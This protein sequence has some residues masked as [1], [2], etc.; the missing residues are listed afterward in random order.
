[1]VR[2][3]LHFWKNLPASVRHLLLVGAS[4][5]YH[6]SRIAAEAVRKLTEE[7]EPQRIRI[8][9]SLCSQILLAVWEEDPLDVTAAKQ[10]WRW[11][12]RFPFLTE[13]TAAL[14]DAV[15]K[16]SASAVRHRDNHISSTE[17]DAI[18]Q[19]HKFPQPGT[20]FSCRTFYW[21]A[22]VEGKYEE[23][24]TVLESACWPQ[25]LDRLRQRYLA[26]I[27]LAQGGQDRWEKIHAR[28]G[29]W[30][31][32]ADRCLQL[33]NLA[34][35][36]GDRRKALALWR[37]CLNLRPWLTHV[38]LRSYDTVNN[39]D[40]VQRPLKGRVSICL[41]T[42]NKA[43][44]LNECLAAL[45]ESHLGEAKI[46]VL[47]NGSTD[48][49]RHIVQTWQDRLGT[50]RLKK[51][52]LPINVGAPAARN[53]LMHDQHVREADW[54]AYLDD[55]A[56]VPAD[57]ME[58]LESA[59]E[60]YPG[61]GVWG[62]RVMDAWAAS[63]IQAVDYHLLPPFQA[64]AAQNTAP[65][66]I[67]M[68]HYETFDQEQFNYMRPCVHVTGCCHLFS[69]KTLLS[70]G[71]FDLRFSPSQFDDL[72][73][74]FRLAFHNKP[75]I[76]QGHLAVRHMN[77]TAKRTRIHTGERGSAGANLYKLH[78][79]YSKNEYRK[80][81]AWN[82]DLIEQDIFQKL[83]EMEHDGMGQTRRGTL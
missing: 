13:D 70:S 73:H 18:A 48:A 66:F 49:T 17:Q 36:R 62:C 39:L 33:G 68:L 76:Y 45:A 42:F 83:E 3:L 38:I 43:R 34:L 63:T 78:H 7:G 10:L 31:S 47:I 46:F 80:L 35:A 65:F 29:A 51:I 20:P 8:L 40:R 57:W 26:F 71:D 21:K 12:S 5:R 74:D 2:S 15:C 37:N 11:H 53:W 82:M 28:P 75:A 24:R 25:P 1:M 4:G 6:L 59:V 14:V 81:I 64:V 32:D 54:I 27:D 79:K 52:D 19:S 9:I 58:A 69:T 23:A 30:L 16:E 61:G 50:D 72:E 22:M 67:S 77:R 55:D 56:L 60:R 41:Y 44:D